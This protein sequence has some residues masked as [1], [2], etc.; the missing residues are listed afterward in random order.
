M[1]KDP[2]FARAYAALANCYNRLSWYVPAEDS[3]AKAEAA[4][5]KALSLDPNL[6]EAYRS[7]AVAKQAYEWDLAGADAAYRRSIELDPDDPIT[8][9][10]YADELL[11]AGRN[12]EA[13]NEALRARELDP[14][15]TLY[16]TLA[17]VYFYSRRYKKAFAEFQGKHDVDRDVFWYVVWIYGS[18]RQELQTNNPT[19]ISDPVGLESQPTICELAYADAM[20]GKTYRVDACLKSRNKAPNIV[21][22]SSYDIA[23]LYAALG[24]NEKAFYWL[25]R[26][27]QEHAWDFSYVKVD[28]RLDSLHRDSRFDALINSMGLQAPPESHPLHVAMKR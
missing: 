22:D 6:P 15:F 4:A 21:S 24:D 11:A 18:H 27:R 5:Q 14:S 23:V 25:N 12:Q 3:F 10:W 7:L 19:K 2:Q 9:R 28:P 13:E 26:A 17:H 1:E 8:H 20:K 16:D